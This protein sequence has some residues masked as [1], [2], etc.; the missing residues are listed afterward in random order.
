MNVNNIQNKTAMCKDDGI[1]LPPYRELF[2]LNTWVGNTCASWP[3]DLSDIPEHLELLLEVT[4]DLTLR[5]MVRE[6][7]TYDQ[8]VDAIHAGE[9]DQ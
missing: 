6:G 8:M 4:G 5:A 2:R 3:V 9:F 7:K 1:P